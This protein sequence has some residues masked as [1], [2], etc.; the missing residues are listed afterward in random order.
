MRTRQENKSNRITRGR[1]P[2][3]SRLLTE[4]LAVL[5]LAAPIAIA[6]C[7]KAITRHTIAAPA[8]SEIMPREKGD[9]SDSMLKL[10]EQPRK[11]SAC[12]PH[13]ICDGKGQ[14]ALE[15]LYPEKSA[16]QEAEKTT[17]Q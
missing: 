1:M 4:G 13:H 2:I 7:Q 12:F 14:V 6:S 10:S 8:A 5:A 16:K 11:R 17:P 3:T 9:G 15:I